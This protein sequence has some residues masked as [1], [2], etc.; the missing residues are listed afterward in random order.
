MQTCRYRRKSEQ[1]PRLLRS[2]GIEPLVYALL[3]FSTPAVLSAAVFHIAPGDVPGLIAAINTA[4]ANGEENT[5]NLEPGTYTLT[6]I[7]NEDF[8][9]SGLP[10]IVGE[11]NINGGNAKATI[12]ERDQNAPGFRIIH[13]EDSGKLSIN[14]LTIRGGGVDVR[15]G[16]AGGGIA[17]G[18]TLTVTQSIIAR[19]I[20]NAGGAIVNFKTARLT[21]STLN[22]N[23]GLVLGGA[24]FNQSGTF[25]ID[26][27]TINENTAPEGGGLFNNPNSTITIINSTISNNVATGFAGGGIENNGTLQ[28][29]N[30]T[31]SRNQAAPGLEGGGIFNGETGRVELRNAI[32]ALNTFLGPDCGDESAALGPV[33]S[34]GNNIIGDLSGCPIALL[35]TDRTGIPD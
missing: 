26:N 18:G 4:N 16:G 28:I 23:N 9:P 32:L 7:N 21:R 17:N 12:I 8:G 31:I 19:N 11:I 3:I 35:P 22:L 30:S 1:R 13:I 10:S 20:A 34:L 15:P 14:G 6:R 29:T 25:A 2:L 27:S 5:I 24:V 33:V